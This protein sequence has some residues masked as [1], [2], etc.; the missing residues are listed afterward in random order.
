MPAHDWSRATGGMFHDFHTAWITYIKS[1]LNHGI[2]PP[3]YFAVSE[4]VVRPIVPDVTTLKVPPSVIGSPNRNGGGIAVAEAVPRTHK[5]MRGLLNPPVAPPMRRIAIHRPDGS[6]VVAFVE[7]IS[8]ANK[9]RAASVENFVDKVVDALEAGLQVLLIDL[10]PHN[11]HAPAG[12]HERIVNALTTAP[13]TVKQ[14]G[15]YPE[16]NR[17]F[18]SYTSDGREF[19]AYL[20]PWSVGADLP[21][22]PLFLE[23]DRYV[24]VPLEDSYRKAW[25]DTPQ[26]WRSILEAPQP[27]P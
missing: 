9:G 7:I 6:Q 23:P 20:E 27:G 12:F 14:H 8:S 10:L 19:A 11:R 21:T 13:L 25:A 2:L 3:G 17:E 1:Q 16:G 5:E 18:V 24:N 4:Q 26:I 22:M 15:T